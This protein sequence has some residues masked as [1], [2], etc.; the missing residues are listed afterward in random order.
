[1][2]KRI[3]ELGKSILDLIL[4]KDDDDVKNITVLPPIGKT[5][6]GIVKGN[7]SENGRVELF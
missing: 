5:D 6:H 1:M 3:L 2:Y 4:I 7:L